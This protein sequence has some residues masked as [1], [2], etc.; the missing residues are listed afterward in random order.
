MGEISLMTV[1]MVAGA[2]MFS[3]LLY[4]LDDKL[5]SKEALFVGFL[6]CM[7]ILTMVIAA[8]LMR[9]NAQLANMQ[10]EAYTRGYG[11]YKQNG[12]FQWN[13]T[14]EKNDKQKTE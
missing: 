13:K 12:D 5:R 1:L 4:Y 14:G 7:P 8:F 9:A 2:C 10:S 3:G 6:F 11:S